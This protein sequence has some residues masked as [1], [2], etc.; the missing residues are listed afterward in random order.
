ML[1]KNIL[2]YN[3]NNFARQAVRRN[4]EKRERWQAKHLKKSVWCFEVEAT[5]TECSL[6]YFEWMYFSELLF[7]CIFVDLG[8]S[9]HNLAASWL[10]S[11][12]ASFA[13]FEM[14]EGTFGDVKFTILELKFLLFHFCE[15][16]SFAVTFMTLIF[17]KNFHCKTQIPNMCHLRNNEI[18][19]F[20]SPNFWECLGVTIKIESRM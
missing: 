15:A 6:M 9:A 19:L 13:G 20:R 7:C 8:V 4:E 10:A 17:Q 14:R 5:G 2:T 18:I 16:I 12:C 3:W 1:F 11:F